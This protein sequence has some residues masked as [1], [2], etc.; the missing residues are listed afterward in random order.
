MLKDIKAVPSKQ[1]KPEDIEAQRKKRIQDMMQSD[2]SKYKNALALQKLNRDPDAVII[3]LQYHLIWTVVNRKPLFKLENDVEKGQV[4]LRQCAEENGGF[5]RLIKIA[6]DHVHLLLESD[7]KKPIDAVIK[8]FN[9]H[10]NK[11]M[12]HTFDEIG[13]QI[14]NDA[15]FVETVG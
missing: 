3:D 10:V 13:G 7:G 4:M 9:K 15:Y 12:S 5:F 2:K 1:V 11:A 6:P 8:R 14:W